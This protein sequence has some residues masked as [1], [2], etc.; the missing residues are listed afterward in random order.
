MKVSLKEN[1]KNLIR[2]LLKELENISRDAKENNT[3]IQILCK[4]KLYYNVSAFAKYLEDNYKYKYSTA[5]DAIQ[6]M[7]DEGEITREVNGY[8]ELRYASK[9]ISNIIQ[10]HL[11]ATILPLETQSDSVY[12]IEVSDNMAP[13]LAELFNTTVQRNDKRFYASA[14]NL[15]LMLDLAIPEE[16]DICEKK[17]FNLT[18][19]FKGFG[20][21]VRD[22]NT[23]Y[24]NI[25]YSDRLEHTARRFSA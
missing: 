24:Q 12:Y 17:P 4:E 7:E 21:I 16:F 13:F 15:L 11:Y 10:N 6:E 20:I 1:C 22:Y 3:P 25:V 18:S 5:R 14:P 9:K 2:K 8:F 23:V 19:F